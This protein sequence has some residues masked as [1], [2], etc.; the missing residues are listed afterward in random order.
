MAVSRDG[1]VNLPQLGPINVGGQLF[2]A[3]QAEIQSR[4][5]HQM[6]GVR[7]SITMAQTRSIQVFVMGDAYE[8][9]AYTISGLGTITSAL[10]AAGGVRRTGSLR[11]VELKRN[12]VL[13]R[14]FDLYDLLIHGDTADDAKLLQGD[15]VLVPSVG[16]TVAVEGQIERPA[17]YE[18]RGESTPGEV[19][20]L[21]GGLTPNA[22]TSKATLTRIMPNGER[23]VL[24]LDLTSGGVAEGLRNGDLINIPRLRPT[25]DAAVSLQ[26][27]VYTGGAYFY[28]A[29]MRLTDVIH[30]VDDLEPDADLHYV[31][32]RRE[33]PPNRHI[34]ALSADLSAALAA[35]GSSA[36]VALVPRDQIT[37]FD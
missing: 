4:V 10:Y 18:I 13:V 16:S 11:N 34:V 7:A 14:K 17:I 5:T 28:R 21:A 35:P 30:S 25:L 3:V 22:D 12:G 37:V 20:S 26:G 6:I 33:L 15:V 19:V 24:P 9:G 27:H 23:V 29:G 1:T 8:P 2:S 31:L 36:D 32:I